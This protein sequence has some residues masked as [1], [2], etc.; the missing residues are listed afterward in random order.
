M[1]YFKGRQAVFLFLYNV[2]NSNSQLKHQGFNRL[3]RPDGSLQPSEMII[4]N[5]GR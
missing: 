3:N 4:I 1:W 5:G 2:N